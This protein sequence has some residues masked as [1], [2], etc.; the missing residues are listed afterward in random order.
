M[1]DIKLEDLC[2]IHT[3]SGVELTSE[4]FKSSWTD[5]DRNIVLFTLDGVTY[6]AVEDP[7]DG[8]RSM[9]EGITVSDRAPSFSFEGIKVLCYMREDDNLAHYDSI[10]MR[11]IINGKIILEVGTHN[12]GDYYP[13]CVFEYFPENMACNA[14]IN[15]NDKAQGGKTND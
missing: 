5:S 6:K 14:E 15:A 9:C 10:I 4:E 3:L 1:A 2:G 12:T 8:Y 11:D 13:Y 7:D